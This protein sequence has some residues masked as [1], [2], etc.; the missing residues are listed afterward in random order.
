MEKEKI[1]VKSVVRYSKDCK[2]GQA[3]IDRYG[4]PADD[5]TTLLSWRWCCCHYTPKG[6]SLD[7]DLEKRE[8][9][10]DLAVARAPPS[11]THLQV[12]LILK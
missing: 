10:L 12:S 1:A 4:S 8:A 5:I 7:L 9:L 11:L 3:Q 6:H 2:Y